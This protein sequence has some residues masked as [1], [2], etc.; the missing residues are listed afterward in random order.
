MFA[1]NKVYIDDM[2]ADNKEYID[3]MFADNKDRGSCL[4]TTLDR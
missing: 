4:L 2:F 1:D 3:D